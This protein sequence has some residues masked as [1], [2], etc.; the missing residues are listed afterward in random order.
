MKV[1]ME[2]G[3]AKIHRLPSDTPE[4]LLG[5]AFFFKKETNLC[6]GI[7]TDIKTQV[8]FFGATGEIRTH[9]LRITSALLYP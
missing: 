1:N 9:D 4:T 8:C 2:L 7:F 6:F 3:N 5:A